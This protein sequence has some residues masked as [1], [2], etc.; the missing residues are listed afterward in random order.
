MSLTPQKLDD[1]RYVVEA[2]CPLTCSWSGVYSNDETSA[3]ELRAHLIELHVGR[4]AE[5]LVD[6]V[7]HTAP[8]K[9]MLRLVPERNG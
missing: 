1:Q 7:I 5:D 4:A 6:Y 2:K 3:A 9:T 8:W